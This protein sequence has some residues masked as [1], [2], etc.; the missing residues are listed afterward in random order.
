MSL[1]GDCSDSVSLNLSLLRIFPL[2]ASNKILQIIQF[3]SIFFR[4]EKVSHLWMPGR[5]HTFSEMLLT[6]WKKA[7]N[8]ITI[9]RL[10]S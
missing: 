9:T 10:I 2:L 5:A 8:A 4:A 1:L 3:I 6:K 7:I